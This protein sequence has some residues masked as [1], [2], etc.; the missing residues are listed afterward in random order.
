MVAAPLHSDRRGGWRVNRGLRGDQ[1]A[2][3]DAHGSTGVLHTVPFVSVGILRI[4]AI[5]L[6]SHGFLSFKHLDYVCLAN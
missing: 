1:S 5:G 2:V 3:N 4:S 6:K